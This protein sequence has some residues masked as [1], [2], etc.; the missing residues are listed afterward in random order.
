MI[1]FKFS[2]LRNFFGLLQNPWD[3]IKFS[4]DS[5]IHLNSFLSV[6]NIFGLPEEYYH[7]SKFVF[8]RF[9]SIGGNEQQCYLFC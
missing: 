4:G 5:R 2:C 3:A 1:H 9:R 6:F 8:F 7:D